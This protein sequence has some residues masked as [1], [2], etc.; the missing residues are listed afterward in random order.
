VRRTHYALVALVVLVVTAPIG[1]A[2][3]AAGTGPSPNANAATVQQECTFPVTATDATGTE[4]TVGEEPERLVVLQ[5]SSAQILWELGLEERVVGMPVKSYTAYLNGSDSKTN[6]INEDG[7]VNRERVVALEPDLVLAPN[8]VPNET[9]TQLREA[10]LTVHKG[11][12]PSSVPGIQREVS[13]YGR[14]IG[15]CERAAEVNGAFNET[16][17][18][19]RENASDRYQPR[20]FY[21]FFNFTAGQGTFTDEVI[22]TA[23]GRNVAAEAGI[24]GYRQVN[25]EQVAERD[26]EVVFVASDSP[27]PSGEP[28]ESTTAFEEGN[29]YRVNVNL[30]NQPA[31]RVVEPM[32]RMQEALA[33]RARA[34]GDGNAT[35][36][37]MATGT[38][39]QTAEP[40]ASPTSTGTPVPAGDSTPN[41]STGDGETSSGDGPGFG[42]VGSLAALL[43]ALA[44]LARR[45]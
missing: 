18:S 41:A 7:S 35:G 40:T 4:V 44:L 28:W 10:G 11:G 29:V 36:T 33:E 30:L 45:R 25:L 27:M 20:A 21:Y 26:P 16:V 34:V 19:I 31:P 43:V 3:P 37:P 24:S 22:E 14:F 6:V 17:E 8:V 23:G 5:A 38:G 42:I 15:S 1:A 12:F 9:V 32:G 39:T 2:A 13:L